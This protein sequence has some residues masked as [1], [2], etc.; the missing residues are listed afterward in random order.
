MRIRK[1][2][3]NN[4]LNMPSWYLSRT[5]SADTASIK[6]LPLH[7]HKKKVFFSQCDSFQQ[8]WIRAK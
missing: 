7:W 1:Q 8:V 5:T 6:T 3:E 2:I 4:C